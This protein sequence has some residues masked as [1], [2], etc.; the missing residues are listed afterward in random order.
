MA[1]L[2][3]NVLWTGVLPSGHDGWDDEHG[4]LEMAR[5][6][7]GHG[8]DPFD[9][10][11]PQDPQRSSK[12]S[13][14]RPIRERPRHRRRWENQSSWMLV[15]TLLG[16]ITPLAS[17]VF[18]PFD[19]CLD[20]NIV[21]S[22][23]VQLQFV[24]LNVSA[25]FNTT[26]PA[27]NLNITIYGN[28][29]GSATTET[30]P[31]PDD[32]RWQDLNE[33]AGKIIDLSQPNNRYSTL[34]TR[35]TLLSYTPYRPGPKRFCESLI[36]G[37]CPLGPVFNVNATELSRLPALSV[38]Q[39]LYS[40][41]AFT[42]LTTTVRV[43]SGDAG[44]T[45]LAC[46]SANITPDL[47]STLKILLTFLPLVILVLVGFATAFAATFSPWGSSD[48]F[49]WTSNYG[50]D[51]DLLRLVTPGFGDCLQYIQ[52]VVLTGALS[53]NYPGYYQP[54]VS[55][56]AWSALMFNT[57]YVSHGNG[58]QSLIDGIYIVNGTY[59]LD[60]LS[61]LVGMSTV[62]DIWDGVIIWLLVIIAAVTVVIQTGFFL[63][64]GYRHLSH[65][66]QQ[67]LR[68]KNMPFTLG[69]II[70]IVFNFFLM[71]LVALSMFQLVIAG[72]PPPAP[73]TTAFAAVLL[74]LL[75][76]FS[77]W[78]LR[79]LATIRP[80]SYLFDDLPTVLLYGP[81]YNTYSDDAAP[82]TLIPLFLQFVRGIAIGAVQPSGIAQLVLL[83]ICEVICILT[84]HAFRPFHSPTS[85]NAYHTFFAVARLMATLLSVAF[86]PSLGITEGS[87]GWIG[88]AILVIHAVVLVF[89]FL[90]NAVQTIVEVGARLTGA[91]GEVGDGGEVA[92]GGL[93]KVFGVRQLS[94]RHPRK[95]HGRHSMGSDATMLAAEH[96][97]GIHLNAAGR[98]RSTSGSSA[99][100]LN[101]AANSD[102]RTSV[103]LESASG[104]GGPNH[105]R[106]A[107]GS[108][109]TPTTPGAST[110]FSYATP[111]VQE[112]SP[113]DPYYRP[114]RAR[115]PTLEAQSPSA[116]TGLPWGVGDLT[117]KRW[118]QASRDHVETGEV[119]AGPSVSGRATP[120]PGYLASREMSDLNVNDPRRPKTDYAVRE[121]DYYY[122]V[123]GPA[124]SAM[125][126]RR[127]GTGPAD[128]TGPISSAAGWIKGLFGGKSKEKGK[129]FEVV[130]SSRVPSSM[131]AARVTS[132]P[133]PK[134][135]EGE[136]YRDESSQSPEARGAESR[137]GERGVG[138]NVG[139]SVSLVDIE[140]IVEDHRGVQDSER[141]GDDDDAHPHATT[142]DDDG[143][144]EQFVSSPLSPVPPSLPRIDT[145]GGIELPSRI[146]SKTSVRPGHGIIQPTPPVPRKSS[147]R[148]SVPRVDVQPHRSRLS[149]VRGSPPSSPPAI[150]VAPRGGLAAPKTN[151]SGS[152]TSST[153]P[154]PTRMP[155]GSEQSSIRDHP[156][157]N[158]GDSRS[159]SIL[160]ALDDGGGGGGAA[161]LGVPARTAADV[162]ERPTS[163]GF[164]SQHRAHDHIHVVVPTEPDGAHLRGSTA[165]IVQE[166]ASR[167]GSASTG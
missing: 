84:L 125:S 151:P 37:S 47:G 105:E 75:V 160:P 9:A 109:Y 110:P 116:R 63:R 146:G 111:E 70:R 137:V 54:V 144:D 34:F 143:D 42:T 97:S 57:S 8:D 107:S 99:V 115:R 133:G 77:V 39:D 1:T 23:P 72:V 53:L 80:R 119:L 112:S 27:R 79:L 161:R 118:S 60:R 30:P 167:N 86:V 45:N 131:M 103:G 120:V 94:R 74:L 142:S 24:P 104:L 51:E 138:G 6:G 88:Y 159:S 68:R 145:G 52:F 19:N 113:A 10:G 59:G 25:H 132:G 95:N 65:T 164:V 156:P 87:K 154:S 126:G 101:R 18:V 16:L 31:P 78:L 96:N 26:D 21:D 29:T 46:I 3:R 121:V 127:L 55:Q 150:G 38:A 124:L 100:L 13:S 165:E 22:K 20:R 152:N 83:A 35:Y 117:T 28:V 66:R 81:L 15:V 76:A 135:R 93:V 106:S 102:G 40:S 62:K 73:A 69:N 147:K 148:I 48:V 49:R 136:P 89:G 61:Q 14:P 17:A 33:T 139:E 5:K 50:R 158:E 114:P 149:A 36:Q 98:P 129:G 32:P 155:F 108:A 11:W 162:S 122:G 2:R 130:R 166:H 140:P 157:S 43:S 90:L 64:W 134:P 153:R 123:R 44:G 58:T 128:P 141:E 4:T 56:A 67:D 41:Y 12:W 92:R 71:P 7:M 82:F 91:G 85:M 163:M